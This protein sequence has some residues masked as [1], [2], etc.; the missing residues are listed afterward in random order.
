LVEDDM[1]VG[2]TV[3]RVLRGSRVVWKRSAEEAVD[4]L[5]ANPDAAVLLLDLNLKTGPMQGDD[6]IAYLAEHRPDLLAS[7]YLMS[8]E[9]EQD[10]EH[11][12]SAPVSY[13]RKPV[14]IRVL[15]AAVQAHNP[16]PA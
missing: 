16:D 10:V 5:E 1:S 3:S 7:T 11:R 4:E 15:R 12:F 14:G 6:L 9:L 2:K 13:I 8:G